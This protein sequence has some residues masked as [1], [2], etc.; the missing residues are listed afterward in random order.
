MI[1]AK[2]LLAQALMARETALTDVDDM[3]A[4]AAVV[5]ATAREVEEDLPHTT[6]LQAIMAHVA[7]ITVM[8]VLAVTTDPEAST[9]DPVEEVLGDVGV[10][11]AGHAEDLAALAD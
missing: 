6:V 3:V 5:A 11:S 7:R 8:A 1:M 4:A 9:A 2:D 10:R